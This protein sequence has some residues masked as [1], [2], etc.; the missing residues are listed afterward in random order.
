M[1]MPR[2]ISEVL[3]QTSFWEHEEANQKVL[4]CFIAPLNP[5]CSKG[6]HYEGHEIAGD[7]L[8]AEN[9]SEALASEH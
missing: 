6:E 5:I 7:T 4:S 8:Y 1:G 2:R 3:K 9:F